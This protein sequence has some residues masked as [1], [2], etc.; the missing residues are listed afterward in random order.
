MKSCYAVSIESCYAVSIESCYAVSIESC[1]AVSIES[2]YAV[3]IE[4]FYAVSI[5]SC[6]AVSIESPQ[7]KAL[8]HESITFNSWSIVE[9]PLINPNCCV[10]KSSE[11][12]FFIT[13]LHTF[14]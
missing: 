9:R 8:V 6:Y 13:V 2:C 7:S 12:S 4:S 11:N 3:S 10:L 5:E 1:Y 14:E